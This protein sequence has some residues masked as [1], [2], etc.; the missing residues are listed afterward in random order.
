MHSRTKTNKIFTVMK[1]ILLL[2]NLF[3]MV[4]MRDSGLSCICL[5]DQ[6]AY[7][8][9]VLCVA[10]ISMSV[11]INMLCEWGAA[12]LSTRVCVFGGVYLSLRVCVCVFSGGIRVALA[13]NYDTH[14][15]VFFTFLYPRNLLP[16]HVTKPIL[17][18]C[19]SIDVNT[20][21]FRVT[22]AIFLL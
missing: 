19:A 4:N 7:R 20:N 6:Q 16:G 17:A 2:E 14:L 18:S 1:I 8:R 13:Y 9:G 10:K 15:I 5:C 3:D 21:L 12:Y 22:T 11:C